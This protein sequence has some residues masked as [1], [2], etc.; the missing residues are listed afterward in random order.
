MQQVKPKKHLGQHFLADK[1]TAKKI[2]DGLSG[3]NKY[4]KVIE[5]GPGTGALTEHLLLTPFD[6]EVVEI[7]EESIRFLQKTYPDLPIHNESFLNLNF[8]LFDEEVAVIGNFPYNISSQ[9]VFKILD[10][11]ESVPEMVGMFQKEVAERIAEPPGSKKYGILSVLTQAYYDVDYLFTVNES[12]FIPPPK[13]KSGVIRLTRKEKEPDCAYKN[14]K[15]VVKIA[16]NQRRKTL[17]NSLK[18]L[19]SMQIFN[20][21]P[22]QLSIDEFVKLTQLLFD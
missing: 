7:D 20:Q 19:K 10:E 3:G 22:E 17:R 12:V 9:I 21:R 16:F 14:L 2:A 1:N 18:S 4:K 8:Q 6:I 11:K 13:V 5:V 15:A